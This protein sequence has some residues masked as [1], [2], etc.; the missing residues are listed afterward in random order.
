M[1]RRILLLILPVLACAVAWAAERE[2]GPAHSWP[3]WRGPLGTGEAP[4]ADPPIRWDEKTN[5]RWKVPLPG[6]S[7]ATPVVWKDRIFVLAAVPASSRI[8]RTAGMFDTYRTSTPFRYEVLAYRRNDGRL[9]WRRTTKVAAPH[10]GIHEDASWASCSPGTAGEHVIATFGSRGVHCYDMDGN[11]QWQRDFGE[12]RIRYQYGE[13]TSPVLSGDRLVIQWDSEARSFLAVLD[14]RTG[15]ELW[16]KDRSDGTSWATPLV[17][18]HRGKKQV[19]VVAIRRV[20]SYDLDTG[21]VLWETRDM[22]AG[23]IP[24]PV[25][26]DGIVYLMGAYQESILQAISLDKARGNAAA[27]D[28]IL[29]ELDRD[30]SYVSSPLLYG[31]SL[32]FLKQYQN[33]LSCFDAKTGKEHYARKRLDGLTQVY[34]SPVAAKGRIYI[35]G[36]NGATIVLR[37][38]PKFEALATNVLDDRFDAS[39][40]IVGRE[41]FLRGH[42]NLYCIAAE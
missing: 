18:E 8:S 41:L 7:H 38:G 25:A 6:L 40:V 37:H 5:I 42:E 4:D 9:L 16:R 1:I 3:Q 19:I 12:M 17:V 35:A 11:L 36:R 32:Y 26:G 24:S 20:Q 14:K 2:T 10:E 31:G 15:K 30:T 13:S 29:W 33:I 28:A 27:S 39:P 21:A 23:P 22:T 34:S